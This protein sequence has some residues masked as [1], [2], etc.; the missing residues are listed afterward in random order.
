MRVEK[1]RADII[2]QNI[3]ESKAAQEARNKAQSKEYHLPPE[4]SVLSVLLVPSKEQFADGITDIVNNYKYTLANIVEMKK[5]HGR[6]ELYVNSILSRIYCEEKGR[7]MALSFALEMLGQN[8]V[9]ETIRRKIS[10]EL[11]NRLPYLINLF[12]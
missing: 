2:K 10:K 12:S 1:S 8:E 3:A 11:L 9:G 6:E 7:A 5:K 4:L